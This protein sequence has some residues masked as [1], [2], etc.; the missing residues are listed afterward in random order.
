MRPSRSALETYLSEIN[1]TRLLTAEEE[2]T[3]ARRIRKG[4]LQARNEMIR[5]N[6]R[7]VVVVAADYLHRGV[8]LLDLIQEGNA[9][10]L[11][12]V[13][14]FDPRLGLRFTD[15][16][17]Q[18]V[19]GAVSRAARQPC[20]VFRVPDKIAL[21]VNKFLRCAHSLQDETGSWP[22]CA[23][24]A[25][26]LGLKPRVAKV[27]RDVILACGISLEG[28]EPST[29]F[30]QALPD[31]GVTPHDQGEKARYV[32]QLLR[33]LDERS[34]LMLKLRFGL[35]SEGPM[36]LAHIGKA[37]GC[38]GERVRQIINEAFGASRRRVSSKT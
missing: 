22:T 8:S 29:R 34:M 14:K 23:E 12:A 28:R 9:G 36:T 1:Q 35:G 13:E 25:A 30:P 6:L 10:L 7:F 4:D 38:S 3:L 5:R 24:V 17:D 37:F 2:I 16:A 27:V 26:D 19:R 11:R 32:R 33:G 20:S 21:L 31:A 15:Y 18:W